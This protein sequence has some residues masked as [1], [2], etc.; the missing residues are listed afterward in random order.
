VKYDA[1]TL[2]LAQFTETS[3]H[4][5]ELAAASTQSVT[6]F[7]YVQYLEVFIKAI[8]A[9][10]KHY[11]VVAPKLISF[12]ELTAMIKTAEVVKYDV[13]KIKQAEVAEL[14][15]KMK[16]LVYTAENPTLYAVYNEQI[17]TFSEVM[18]KER[19]DIKMEK[20]E[21]KKY[22]EI[23]AVLEQ[24]ETVSYDVKTLTTE[25]AATKVDEY[26]KLI[27]TASSEIV[28]V[29]YAHKFE[30]MIVD[31]KK[32]TKINVKF[33]PLPSYE[34]IVAVNKSIKKVTYDAKAISEVQIAEKQREITQNMVSCKSEMEYMIYVSMMEK[35]I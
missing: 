22:S 32:N 7:F 10:K 26:K 28:Y 23:K 31:I 15:A 19:T 12:T 35:M 13:K 4:I 30:L 2:T 1:K 29:I 33:D 11:A 14:V 8:K 25:I 6:Y 18:T 16:S 9:E 27:A 21:I 20:I 34:Q 5:A 17:V 24:A 3:K